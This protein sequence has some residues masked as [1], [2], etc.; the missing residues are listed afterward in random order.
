V[1]AIIANKHF[2]Q[3]TRGL[4]TTMRPS[5]HIVNCLMLIHH[6]FISY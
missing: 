6:L 3:G 4:D 5:S 1:L 2:K